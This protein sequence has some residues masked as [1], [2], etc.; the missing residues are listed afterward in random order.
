MRFSLFLHI[1]S[2]RGPSVC[3]LSHSWSLLKP[4]DEFRCQSAATLCNP[5]TQCCVSDG[6]HDFKE[7]ENLRT[8]CSQTTGRT[9]YGA[10]CT[11]MSDSAVC[12]FVTVSYSCPST[13]LWMIYVEQINGLVHPYQTRVINKRMQQAPTTKDPPK[14]PLGIEAIHD[15]RQ[16][17][18][19]LT[20]WTGIESDHQVMVGY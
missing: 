8:N 10:Y 14:T 1:S 13:T 4:F 18:D 11:Q 3:R 6:A 9:T 17:T 5:I 16:T 19:A 7:K 15:K 20:R 12:Q 2:Q